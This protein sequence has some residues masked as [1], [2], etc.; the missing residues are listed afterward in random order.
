LKNF[1][2]ETTTS[3]PTKKDKNLSRTAR[4]HDNAQNRAGDADHIVQTDGEHAGA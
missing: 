3:V 2:T 1:R 4:A